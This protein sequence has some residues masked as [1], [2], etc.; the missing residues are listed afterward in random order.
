MTM[1][2]AKDGSVAAVHRSATHT[3]TKGEQAR[4]FLHYVQFAIQTTFRNVL[5]TAL[6]KRSSAVT[7]GHCSRKLSAKYSESYTVRWCVTAS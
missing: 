4:I 5:L 2:F 1:R 3:L 7:K 6:T